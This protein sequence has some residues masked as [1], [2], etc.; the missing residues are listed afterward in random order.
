MGYGDRKEM[1][2]I[3]YLR[4]STGILSE[5]P[6]L[7]DWEWKTI[8]DFCCRQAILGVGFCGIEKLPKEQ[9]PP[10]ELLLQWLAFIQQIENQNRLLNER[11]EKLQKMFAEAGFATIILKGQGNA[12]MYPNPLL[13]QPGDIDI[14]VLPKLKVENGKL[15]INS[16]LDFIVLRLI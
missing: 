11:C 15:K 1:L 9:K 12:L 2:G 14:W 10:Y 6:K 16:I 7:N 5:M 3:S 8:Y 13:R 4:Y